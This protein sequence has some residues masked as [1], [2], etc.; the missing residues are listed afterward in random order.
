MLGVRIRFCL[1]LEENLARFVDNAH[2]SFFLRD[3]ESDILLP[4]S[5]PIRLL[6]EGLNYRTARSGIDRNYVI[7]CNIDPLREWAPRGRQRSVYWIDHLPGLLLLEL[8]GT[9]IAKG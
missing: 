6:S 2:R 8:D 9:D 4:G 7:V 1:S 3:V 5:H